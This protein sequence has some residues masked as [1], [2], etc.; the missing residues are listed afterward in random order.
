MYRNMVQ[1]DILQKYPLKL[2][3]IFTNKNDRVLLQFTSMG[4]NGV[5]FNIRVQ[6]NI[7]K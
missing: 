1:I 2:K 7:E 6:N 3:T 4:V 5:S